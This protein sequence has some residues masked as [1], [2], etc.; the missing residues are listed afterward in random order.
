MPTKITYMDRNEKKTYMKQDKKC[1]IDNTSDVVRIDAGQKQ[2]NISTNFWDVI[3]IFKK[4]CHYPKTIT[5]GK[6]DTTYTIYDMNL[7]KTLKNVYK[8]NYNDGNWPCGNACQSTWAEI[9]SNTSNYKSTWD[10]GPN[11]ITCKN[12]DNVLKYRRPHDG[13]VEFK[14][15]KRG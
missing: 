6:P 1:V 8:H 5:C 15:F 10:Y 12:M 4:K 13:L 11:T 3:N 2:C 9:Q 14:C 7:K